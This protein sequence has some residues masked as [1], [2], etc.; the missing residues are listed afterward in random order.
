MTSAFSLADILLNPIAV[1][2][3]LVVLVTA[4][5]LFAVKR[6]TLSDPLKAVCI[7]LCIIC[8]VYLGFV[9]WAT[10][11]FGNAHPAHDP[12]PYPT[13][14]GQDAL[15]GLPIPCIFPVCGL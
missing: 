9:L 3:T 8:L 10:I 4:A 7:L 5:V 13:I 15:M 1:A 12:A 2:V 11:G 14:A 6:K